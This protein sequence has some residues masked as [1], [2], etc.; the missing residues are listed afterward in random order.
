MF[1]RI[2]NTPPHHTPPWNLKWNHWISVLNTVL[3]VVQLNN[4]T[5]R[6]RFQGEYKH[7]ENILRAVQSG[8]GVKKMQ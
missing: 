8:L 6:A 3:N 4:T 2:L 5:S 7:A 1:E